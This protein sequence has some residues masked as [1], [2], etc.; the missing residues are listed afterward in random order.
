LLQRRIDVRVVALDH[1]EVLV[2]PKQLEVFVEYLPT[3]IIAIERVAPATTAPVIV[4]RTSTLSNVMN[5]G[6]GCARI[7]DRGR[8]GLHG[9]S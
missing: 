4:C 8:R 5:D 6:L 3:A 2:R 9:G 7:S 1:F